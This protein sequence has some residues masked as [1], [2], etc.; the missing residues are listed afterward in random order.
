VHKPGCSYQT[1]DFSQSGG[2]NPQQTTEV[3]AIKPHLSNQTKPSA[4]SILDT[5]YLIHVDTIQ[6]GFWLVKPI[7]QELQNAR[8]LKK[9]ADSCCDFRK[10]RGMVSYSA[11]TFHVFVPEKTMER[12]PSMVM[13]NIDM[14]RSTMFNR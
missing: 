8:T 14:E 2:N 6:N 7:G 11:A 5:G 1:G 13:T 9:A 10:V 12:L 3:L 4:G